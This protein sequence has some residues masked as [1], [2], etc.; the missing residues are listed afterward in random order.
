MHGC[1]TLG[2]ATVH[3]SQSPWNGITPV[4]RMIQNQLGHLL[5]LQMIKLDKRILL[6]LQKAL[7]TRNRSSWVFTSL[8]FFILL[9]VRELD[10]A[11]NIFWGRYKDSV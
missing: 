10:A 1:E 5:E 11:R 6:T 2:M 3:D 7:Q 9:H 4:P 8:A